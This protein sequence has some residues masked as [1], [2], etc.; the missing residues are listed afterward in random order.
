MHIKKFLDFEAHLDEATVAL[1][2]APFEYSVPR[3]GL[4]DGPQN[5][6]HMSHL[7]ESY[8]PR[9]DRSL[10]EMKLCDLGGVTFGRDIIESMRLITEEIGTI[11]NKKV[12]VIGGE[13]TVTVG[14]VEGLKEKYPELVIIQMDAH[15]DLR[16][17][18]EGKKYSHACV[19]H[20]CLELV[21]PERIYQLGIRS[22]EKEEFELGRQQCHL[23]SQLRLDEVTLKKLQGIPIYLTIDID[24]LDPAYAPG[25]SVPEPCGVSPHE[26]FEA[27]YSLSGLNIIGFDVVEVLPSYDPGQITA[28]IAAKIIRE[29]IL[30]FWGGIGGS[31]GD[32]EDA[33]R[34]KRCNTM[35]RIS[36]GI[37]KG[38]KI[39]A[40]DTMSTRPTLSRVKTSLFD[41]LVNR[42]KDAVILDLYSGTG[43]IGIEALSRG[44]K[45]VIFVEN[46]V[47]QARLIKENLMIVKFLEH[48]D[49]ITL[50]VSEAIQM[51]DK[52]MARDKNMTGFDIIYLA[53]PFLKGLVWSTIEAIAKS[54]LISPGG[55]VG[56]EHHKKEEVLPLAEGLSATDPL[57]HTKQRRYGDIVISFY[58]RG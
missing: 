4:A 38:K 11:N 53:P 1:L 36:G 54:N 32:T 23:S 57:I 14:V 16:N 13:H 33:E 45:R 42:V 56:A 39:K 22:G 34:E 58:E 6:R 49:I 35:I 44:A 21:G 19:M 17:E 50:T 9:L 48:A 41:M 18:Y 43:N 29:A 10:Q 5:I 7:L 3:T 52:R 25:V 55:L 27:I 8:S 51:L 46:N 2:G 24:I 47:A 26:L 12:V 28:A 15:A 37:A 40:L 30:T 20:R 31:H